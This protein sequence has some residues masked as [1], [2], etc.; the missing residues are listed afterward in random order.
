MKKKALLI[1]IN[2]K[3]SKNELYGCINDIY[4]IKKFLIEEYNFNDNEI[5]MMNED[6]KDKIPTKQ[7]IINNIN[8]LVR[9]NDEN[10]R[11]FFHYSGHG[12]YKR[13]YSGDEKDYLD[14][15]ICPLDYN[16]SG[17]IIDD[18]L[19]KLLIEPLKEGSKLTCIFDCCHSG[20]ILDLRCN[21]KVNINKNKYIYEISIDKNYKS[22]KPNVLLISGCL[23]DQTSADS[24]ISGKSQG[25]LTY[26]FIE[27]HRRLKK[28][29]KN[30]LIKNIIKDLTKIL[31]ENGYEQKP[32]LST[33]NLIDLYNEF[34][35][36]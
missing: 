16:Y 8:E 35:I 33:G 23:D 2:Y 4:N 6:I 32:K 30:I 5:I 20:T 26:S 13:D 18:E 31:Y 1:G 10:S 22:I 9:D 34:N 15:T 36:L 21:Y 11:L 12:Y 29:R 14:E 24:Y 27:I 19:K 7:N 25:A 3:G 17:V 28:K